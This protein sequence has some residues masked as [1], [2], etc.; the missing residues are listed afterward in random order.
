MGKA[1]KK[2]WDENDGNAVLAGVMAVAAV[3]Y[4]YYL[5]HE[6][7]N[8]DCFNEGLLVYT[9]GAFDVSLGRWLTPVCTGASGF[10]V[11]PLIYLVLYFVCDAIAAVILTDIWKIRGK[12]TRI[13]TGEIGRAHV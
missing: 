13:L 12:I 3:S 9:N 5:T 1:I 7:K 8:S 10:I 4:F 2:W 11:D 6:L